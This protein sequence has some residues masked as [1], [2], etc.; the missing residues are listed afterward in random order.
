MEG[1]CLPDILLLGG[2]AEARALAM[3]LSDMRM[4]VVVSLAGVTDQPA[5]YRHPLR[6]GGFGGVEGLANHI[7]G[8]GYAAVIDATHP[9][10]VQISGNAVAASLAAGVP[11]V[12][13]TRP[14]WQAKHG[15]IWHRVKDLGC[16][17][18]S[19][20]T[21]ARVFATTG[22]GTF[23]HFATEER[24][25]TLLRVIRHPE[26]P[27]MKRG[28]LRVADPPF[29][30]ED[31]VR[32]MR[33]HRITHVI[34]KNAG[35]SGTGKLQAARKLGLPVIMIDR[36]VLPDCTAGFTDIEAVCSWLTDNVAF[37]S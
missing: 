18:D 36:P 1:M 28:Q 21:D 20:P 7:R 37:R 22:S 19:V 11:C 12:R 30:V 23:A 14:Q 24:F 27:T 2:T 5:D 33:D 29:P 15:D 8:K 34:S 3:R 6:T 26:N 35:G 16:A 4:D 13:L 25:W 9:F 32:L 31:E 10:A 17:V